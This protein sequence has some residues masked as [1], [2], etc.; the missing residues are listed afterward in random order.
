MA[1]A[2]LYSLFSILYSLR[3]FAG[4]IVTN[5][6]RNFN[7]G[8]DT[9]LIMLTAYNT[10][11]N[12][13]GSLV[14]GE[15]ILW[16]AT[17]GAFS[18]TMDAGYYLVKFPGLAR[19][20]NITVPSSGGPYALTSLSTNLSTFSYT[21]AALNRISSH[22]LAGDF[23]TLGTNNAGLPNE[24]IVIT[25]ESG[26][27]GGGISSTTATNIAAF[28]AYLATNNLASSLITRMTAG[29]NDLSTTLKAL[30][31]A[32]ANTNSPNLFTPSFFGSFY[33]WGS[34]DDEVPTYAF[35][36]SGSL[37][38]GLE[39]K[40]NLDGAD[41]TIE[42]TGGF[43][44]S[45]GNLHLQHG[46]NVGQAL[47]D[48]GITNA[49]HY[50]GNGDL[51]TN[52]NATEL[53]TGNVA[54]DRLASGTGLQVLRRNAGNNALEFATISTGGGD[55]LAANNLSD[56]ANAGTSRT[57]LAA[58]N[59]DN[60]TA[61]TVADAR[62]AST[63]ARD[64]EVLTATND[65]AGVLKALIAVKADTNLPHLWAPRIHGDPI[66]DLFTFDSSF[67]RGWMQQQSDGTVQ[68][69]LNGDSLTNLNGTEIRSG[70]VA[71]ARIASTI[72]R[73]SEWDTIGEIETATGVNIILNTEIDTSAELAA[74]LGDETGS[75]LA[76]FAT[77]PTLTTPN[78][79]VATAT[80][81]NKVTITAPASGSTLTIAD[82]K[83]LSVTE[84]VTLNRQSSTGLPVEFCVAA[85]DET[86]AI[87]TGTGK[88][89][90]RAPYAFTLTELRASV[91]T[92]PTGST[93]LIDVNESGTT[94]IS[95]KIMIDA[96]EKTSTTA[97]TPYVISDSAIADDAEISVDF[98][99]VGS[100]VAG[101]GVKIWI[102][103]YR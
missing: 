97:A 101:A 28:Q 25:G 23:I 5:D 17:N 65:L 58:H 51:L 70:T 71:D 89:T 62:I 75:G 90:F 8:T 56:V 50:V 78:I 82:G 22:V 14:L 85:S 91:N 67:E 11:Q 63:I 24:Q 69:T 99:Q 10:P 36:S 86:T 41:G 94:V 7:Q 61:G 1:R 102:K 34:S 74:I 39:A 53:R 31:A 84:S 92:A 21:N 27:G 42:S 68:V 16:G 19:G 29:T 44:F 13:G 12:V 88:V 46:L 77:S 45:G 103:G 98:D 48:S 47:D 4:V 38:L 57:N 81:V 96:S 40:I 33:G 32:K 6:V 80:T 49:G 83:T 18:I 52:L 35:D 60:L 87:T 54:P 93:I 3:S 43:Q 30:I 95:T 100:T 79:G 9:R 20:F 37:S 76:V 73:D 2:I 72:T 66:F 15:S 55:L 26:G 59:G 64:S